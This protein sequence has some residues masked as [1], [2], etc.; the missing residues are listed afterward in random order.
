MLLFRNSRLV[1]LCAVFLA[2]VAAEAQS[3]TGSAM[4]RGEISPGAAAGDLIVELFDSG[5]H[6]TVGRTAAGTDGQ[7][8]FYGLAAGDYTLRIL[9][10]HGNVVEQQFVRLVRSLTGTQGRAAPRRDS[11]ARAVAAGDSEEG[12]QG[13]RK[14][15]RRHR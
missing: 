3:K 13:I 15:R 11:V 12:P 1:C 5:T 4:L 14:R 8:G 7:F 10:R 6:M 9:D 2:A